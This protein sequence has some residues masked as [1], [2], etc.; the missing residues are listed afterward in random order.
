MRLGFDI[1]DASLVQDQLACM[2]L[3]AGLTLRL[4]TGAD[5]VEDCP[6]KLLMQSPDKKGKGYGAYAKYDGDDYH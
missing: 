2:E 4:Q 3:A 6:P 5:K 1:P